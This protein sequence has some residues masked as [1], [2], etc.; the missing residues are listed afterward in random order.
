MARAEQGDWLMGWGRKSGA[1]M[2]ATGLLA[3]IGWA[4]PASA[5]GSGSA[6]LDAVVKRGQMLCGIAGTVPGLLAA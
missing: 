5:Q 4:A 2:L 1:M 3:G 6:T